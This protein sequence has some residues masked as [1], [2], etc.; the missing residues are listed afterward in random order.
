MVSIPHFTT[1]TRSCDGEVVNLV[2]NQVVVNTI[3]DPASLTR[4]P[5]GPETVNPPATQPTF[6]VQPGQVAYVTLRLV[7]R[8]DEQLARRAGISVR[9]QPDATDGDQT[10]QDLDEG[11]VDVSPP[12]ISLG[13]LA[14]GLTAEASTA[15]GAAVGFVVTS[16]DDSG[17]STV[18][19][20]R[21][22][23]GQPTPS[24]V[25]AD[26]TL[27]LYAL[28]T[29]QVTCTA[30]DPAGNQ[31]TAGFPISILDTTAPTLTVPA[32]ITV[33]AISAAGAVV[34]YSATA[35]DLVDSTPTVTCTPP[36]G[37]TFPLGSTTVSCTARDDSGNMVTRTFTI[38]VRD[39]APPGSITA[40]VSPAF[41]WPPNGALVPVTVS[42]AAA[43]VGTGV[44]TIEWR[45]LDEYKLHQ[46]SGVGQRPW[47]RT[48]QF[49]GA[50]DTGPARKRQE[51][52]RLHDPAH[53]SGQGRQSARARVAACGHRARS[54]R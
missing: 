1:I 33:E 8:A 30:V 40:T 52:P 12:V 6:F 34:N 13:G 53:C 38:T 10:D 20:V 36:S 51:R 11:L 31:A 17:E 37:A 45:V 16:T 4:T 2:E 42:G 43:D 54:E 9:S 23:P 41:L 39:T 7:G 24:P 5:G 35:T 49:P 21:V 46:P 32:P 15:N 27:V 3:V 50:A 22:G 47:K 48:V 18:S 26:G 28:G 14:G 19:C 44:G 25:P 29:W